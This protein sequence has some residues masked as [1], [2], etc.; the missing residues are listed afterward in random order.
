MVL[1]PAVTV[2]ALPSTVVPLDTKPLDVA[3]ELPDV[4]IAAAAAATLGKPP[5]PEGTGEGSFG[6]ASAGVLIPRFVVK[7]EAGFGDCLTACDPSVFLSS[8]GIVRGL[9]LCCLF[10]NAAAPVSVVCGVRLGSFEASNGG[11]FAA[12]LGDTGVVARAAA[13]VD[14]AVEVGLVLRDASRVVPL[15][16]TGTEA[17]CDDAI[18]SNM[19]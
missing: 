19:P 12:A 7:I 1:G 18:T 9:R 2:P 3:G 16:A 15:V 4:S 13:A 5:N 14:A 11:R 17:Y 6:G 8:R 10:D